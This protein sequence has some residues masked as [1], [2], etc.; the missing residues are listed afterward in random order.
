MLL[1]IRLDVPCKTEQSKIYKLL[2]K[3]SPGFNRFL[4]VLKKKVDTK[5]SSF[6]FQMD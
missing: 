2:E 5:K 3:L 4:Q 1:K 6:P